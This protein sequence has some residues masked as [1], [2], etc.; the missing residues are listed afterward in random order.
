M[1]I[2]KPVYL[3][4]LILELSKILMYRFWYDYGKPKYGE[5]AKLLYG[6]RHFHHMYKNMIFG[7]HCRSC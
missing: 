1:I 4:L 2:N 3:G 5:K 6:Y 7:T